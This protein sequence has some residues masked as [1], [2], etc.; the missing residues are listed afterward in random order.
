MVEID[1]EAFQLLARKEA[2][3][4]LLTE[5]IE[6]AEHWLALWRERYLDRWQAELATLQAELG[7]PAP[8]AD[9]PQ[10]EGAEVA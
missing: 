4:D 8:A 10:A 1:D 2:R 6:G 9:Q 3:R 7:E 5:L